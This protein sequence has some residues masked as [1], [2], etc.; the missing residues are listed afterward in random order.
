MIEGWARAVVRRRMLVLACWAIVVAT[1]LVSAARLPGLL[2]T[3]LAVPG[4]GSQ[5]ANTILTEHFGQNIE[6]SFTVVFPTTGHSTPPVSGIA[7]AFQSAARVVPGSRTFPL[8][9]GEGVVYGYIAS[10]LDLRQAAPYTAALRTALRKEGFGRAYVTGAPALQQDV[11]PVLAA[12]LRLGGVIAVAVALTLLTA[13]LGFSSVVLLPFVVAACT[14][15][16]TLALVYLLAHEILMVL[17]VP[18]LVEL[19]GLGLAIDYSLLIVHR[20]R[21]N[22][23]REDLAGG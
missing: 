19:I 20:F 2:S 15:T 21:E 1:G 14:T 11:E 4:T 13:T 12:D 8:Q 16:A 18:N 23:S 3:S 6:G 5:E 22:V 7:R 17:Y 10:P 9:V